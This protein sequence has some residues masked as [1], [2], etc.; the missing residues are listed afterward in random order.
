VK[1]STSINFLFREVPFLQRFAAA[2]SAGFHGVDIQLLESPL[3]EAAAAAAEAGINI[4]VI[5]VDMGDLLA[6]GVGLSGVPGMEMAFQQAVTTAVEAAQTLGASFVHLGPSLVPPDVKREDCLLTY[7]RNVEQVL[8]LEAFSS[9]RL[10]PL[11]E[12][13]NSEDMP[14]VLFSDI[15]EAVALLDGWFGD[16]VG[17][18]FDIYHVAKSGL[19]PVVAWQRHAARVRHVQFSDLPSRGEPGSGS[20]DF[21]AIFAAIEHSGYDGYLGAEYFSS[22]PTL[23]TLGWMCE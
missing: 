17:L 14:S 16:R 3:G 19:D 12:P 13:I 2:R 6:G 5:N 23:E 11:L 20:L 10:L 4:V 7:R 15:D 8:A 22:R 1:F 18:Q 9:G 21:Q